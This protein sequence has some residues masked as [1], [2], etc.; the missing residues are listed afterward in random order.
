MLA[1]HISRKTTLVVCHGALL[2]MK[3]PVLVSTITDGERLTSLEKRKQMEMSLS[4]MKKKVSFV[5]TETDGYVS[6]CP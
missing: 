4:L 5:T 2:G 3:P 6:Q 1:E